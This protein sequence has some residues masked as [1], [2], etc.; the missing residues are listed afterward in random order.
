MQQPG[1]GLAVDQ[2]GAMSAVANKVMRD[3]L[4]MLEA[5][6]KRLDNRS[7]H[8][9]VHFDELYRNTDKVWQERLNAEERLRQEERKEEERRRQEERKEEERLRQG[10]HKE[11]ERLRQE[12]R[13]KEERLRQEE[14]KEEER[15]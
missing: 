5:M 4:P 14:R 6:E 12:E 9:A 11:A 15:L 10:D 7:S 13:T 3:M 1:A 2:A 8:L